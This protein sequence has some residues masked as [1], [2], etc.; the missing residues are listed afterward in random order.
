MPGEDPI[1]ENA[2]WNHFCDKEL[3]YFF[4]HDK[5]GAQ[6]QESGSNFYRVPLHGEL[7]SVAG[8]V[9]RPELNGMRGEILNG[10]DDAGRVVVRLY[11]DNLQGKSGPYRK[12]RIAPS[13]LV[14]ITGGL[15]KQGNASSPALLGAK[16]KEGSGRPPSRSLSS[17]GLAIGSN[18]SASGM[19]RSA[20]SVN[21][22]SAVRRNTPV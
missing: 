16:G 9:S 3:A 11:K 19:P 4:K 6:A 18:L 10:I 8:M 2:I 1:K 20:V 14:P 12:M 21:S 22:A 15:P 13:R 5:K 7:V 17:A